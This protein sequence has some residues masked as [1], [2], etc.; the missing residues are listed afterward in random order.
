MSGNKYKLDPISLAFYS[1]KELV[2]IL[3]NISEESES[4]VTD[5]SIELASKIVLLSDAQTIMVELLSRAEQAYE[6]HKLHAESEQA[7]KSKQFREDWENEH[8]G[9]TKYP[10]SS[11]FENLA[12]G[13]TRNLWEKVNESNVRYKR[14]K[15]LRDNYE[16]KINASKKLL[17]TLE[18]INY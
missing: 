17:A 18:M 8:P 3:T 1:E 6:N 11:Y 15:N 2:E 16:T 4:Y 7:V 10:A 12:K 9:I 5:N 13:E 14:F